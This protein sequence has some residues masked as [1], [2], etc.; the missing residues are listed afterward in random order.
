MPAT[1]IVLCALG[2]NDEFSSSVFA[3]EPCLSILT[4]RLARLHNEYKLFS[5]AVDSYTE[6]TALQVRDYDVIAC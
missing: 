6:G 3:H 5:D 4:T 1:K 2:L